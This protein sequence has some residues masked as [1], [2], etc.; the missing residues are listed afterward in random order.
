MCHYFFY[1]GTLLCFVRH[2]TLVVPAAYAVGS[3]QA[4]SSRGGLCVKYQTH[5]YQP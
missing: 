4:L 3:T 1:F 5:T 2:I